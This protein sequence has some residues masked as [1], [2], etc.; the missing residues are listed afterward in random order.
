MIPKRL[1]DEL[2]LT[3][4]PVEVFRDGSAVRIEAATTSG[5]KQ[6][7]NRLVIPPSGDAF[8]DDDVRQIRLADQR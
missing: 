6:V 3:A 5:L 7:A 1:R 4:G 8:D 2:G